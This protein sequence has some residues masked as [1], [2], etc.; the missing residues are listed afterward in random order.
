MNRLRKHILLDLSLCILEEWPENREL[1]K[2]IEENY[3][4]FYQPIAVFV[5]QLETYADTGRISE[6]RDRLIKDYD[7]LNKSYEGGFYY[8]K[9]PHRNPNR[10]RVIRKNTGE[11][12]VRTDR[13]IGRNDPCPCGSGKKYKNCCGR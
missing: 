3:P 1:L 2:K 7:R 10:I 4:I 6:L 13:K 12:F 8:K 5:K 9:Y 11:P